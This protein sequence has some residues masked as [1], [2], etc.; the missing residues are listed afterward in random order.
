MLMPDAAACGRHRSGKTA[1]HIMGMAGNAAQSFGPVPDGIEPGHHCQQHLR[2][3]DIRGRFFPTD[4]LFP[5]LQR[6]PIGH[7]SVAVLTDTNKA[8]RNGTLVFCQRCKESRMRTTIT[9]WH[10]KALCRAK[11][12]VSSQCAGGF[13]HRQG[14][15]VTGHDGHAAG[16]M[17]S[18]N[19]RLDVTYSATAARIADQ[20]TKHTVLIGGSRVLYIKGDAKWPGAGAQNGKGLRMRI[21]INTEDVCL[22]AM[23]PECHRHAFSRRCRLVKQRSVGNIHPGEFRHHRLIIE[24]GFKAALRDFRLIGGVGRV[25]ARIFKHISQD[26]RRRMAAIIS[27]ANQ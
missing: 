4:M 22:A 21:W 7:L 6:Q 17:H 2:G 15:Q 14:Q 20:H 10:P 26:D 23:C 27:H 11:H 13:Q 12:D 25:P 24:N 3:T 18:L 9:H 16:G 8:A 1:G 19:S 5:C